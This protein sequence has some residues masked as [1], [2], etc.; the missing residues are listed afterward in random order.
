MLVEPQSHDSELQVVEELPTPDIGAVCEG[1][2]SVDEGSS[3]KV[4]DPLRQKNDVTEG[5]G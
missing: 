1:K 3:Q 2:F 4:G 5:E